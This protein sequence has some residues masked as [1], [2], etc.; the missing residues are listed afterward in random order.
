MAK[1]SG[2][3]EAR[4]L[5]G[6]AVFTAYNKKI[7]DDI[8]AKL[9]QPRKMISPS[10]YQQAVFDWV[11]DPSTVYLD[12]G[13]SIERQPKRNAVV[14]AVAGSGKTTTMIE[15]CRLLNMQ[16]SSATFHSIGLRAWKTVATPQIKAEK[17]EDLMEELDI[18]RNLRAVTGKLVSLAKQRGIGIGGLETRGGDIPWLEIIE[19]FDLEEMIPGFVEMHYVIDTA[20]TV[21]QESIHLADQVIDFEDMIYM[22]L[23]AGVAIPQFDWVIV[24][25]LQDTNP[26]RRELARRMIGPGGRFIGV[27]DPHQAIYGF[28]GAD[29]DAMDLVVEQ[30]DCVRLP[31]TV[32]YRCARSI[33]AHAQNWVSHIEA[34]EKA[35]E[36]EVRHIKLKEFDQLLDKTH[37]RVT[38]PREPYFG[39]TVADA[40]L[41]RNT[42]PLIETAF[43]MI[44]R[45]IPCHVEGRDIGQGL[46]S[47]VKKWK[48]VRN[49]AQLREQLEDYLE[50]ET[51]KFLKRGRRDK[52]ASLEDK[53][54]TLMVFMSSLHDDDNLFKLIESINSLFKDTETGKK[55]ATVTL[56]T[57][58]KSKGR[59]WDRVFLLGRNVF[60]PSPYAKQ[61]WQL[62]QEQNLIYV[63]VTR[64]MT[65]LVEVEYPL[66]GQAE[67]EPKDSVATPRLTKCVTCG[68]HGFSPSILG[69]DRC[70]FCDGTVGGNPP[71][72][73][74]AEAFFQKHFAEPDPS[75][76]NFQ[77]ISPFLDNVKK[78]RLPWPDEET[79]KDIA[80]YHLTE[81]SLL[82]KMPCPKDVT[83]IGK[84]VFGKAGL[85]CLF[86]GAIQPSGA[87][88]EALLD[89]KHD[90]TQSSDYSAQEAEYMRLMD[91]M[92][93]NGYHEGSD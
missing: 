2:F 48:S 64:A 87:R 17:I 86:C 54:G 49:V 75:K 4:P 7:A 28:T 10:S 71:E 35:P 85:P 24:D 55:A 11:L 83:G 33:V 18:E 41:C 90:P 21:L 46:I 72:E 59:E 57:V 63:A 67:E 14:E 15:V 80:N 6:R 62:E 81:M 16:V 45:R 56:S 12:S 34:F 38:G 66:P 82:G 32:T 20:Q 27:G 69:P 1:L 93:A 19:H 8:A 70:E 30:F 84:H 26:T 78:P 39:L 25:E 79:R 3:S 5:G 73:A 50:A 36:G 40:I 43:D 88:I 29:N 65:T 13:L 89:I 92:R 58:H 23:Q 31:L 60:M 47:L 37:T 68:S 51:A 44:R 76:P 42:R 22:P 77:N 61:S 9:A 74:G 91:D 52:V 53:I